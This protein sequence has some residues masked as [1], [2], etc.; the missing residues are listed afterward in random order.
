MILTV[1]SVWMLNILFAEG[2]Y[3]LFLLSFSLGRQFIMFD[4]HCSLFKIFSFIV[5]TP[6]VRILQNWK[7]LYCISYSNLISCCH[8]I[9]C[10]EEFSL[11]G[12]NIEELKV[13][14]FK[15]WFTFYYLYHYHLFEFWNNIQPV[16]IK[17]VFNIPQSECVHFHLK[18]K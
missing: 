18:T 2:I 17:C 11:V 14:T 3:F 4:L 7:H 10:M 1:F 6:N 16:S 12:L 9:S 13:I 5:L 8:T 15:N